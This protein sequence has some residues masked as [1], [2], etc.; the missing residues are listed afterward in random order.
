[1]Y[2]YYTNIPSQI[3]EFLENLEIDYILYNRIQYFPGL[4]M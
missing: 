2:P 3:Q 4:G 1:M